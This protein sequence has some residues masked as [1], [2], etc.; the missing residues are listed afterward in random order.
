MLPPPPG[1]LDWGLVDTF[2]FSANVSEY[3]PSPDAPMPPWL[4]YTTTVT[5]ALLTLFGLLGNSLTLYGSIKFNAVSIDNVSRV[6]LECL[7]ILDLLCVAAWMLAP[8]ITLIAGHWVLGSVGCILQNF[9]GYTC[10]YFEAFIILAFSGFRLYSLVFPL[11]AMTLT[12]RKVILFVVAIGLV[13][14]TYKLTVQIYFEYIYLFLPDVLFCLAHSKDKSDLNDLFR[15]VL[16]IA[17]YL[18]PLGLTVL[19]N[20][21]ILVLVWRRSGE[22]PGRNCIITI[23]A[24]CWTFILSAVPQVILIVQGPG[25]NYTWFFYSRGLTILGMIGNPIIY[26]VANPRFRRFLMGIVRQ[27]NDD[28]TSSG[29]RPSRVTLATMDPRFSRVSLGTMDP[30]LSGMDPRLI[31]LGTTNPRVSAVSRL[32]V[33]T[34]RPR[35]SKTSRFTVEFNAMAECDKEEEK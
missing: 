31:A 27:R 1:P 7:A 26:T 6:L 23:S 20:V 18:V 10:Y 33:V 16:R 29:G 17:F 28:M 5:L 3:I 25:D 22:M 13:Y 24:V 2:M 11:R 19:S 8:C 12:P 34:P 15:N 4:Y 9:V 35:V 14:F 30:R 21:G 32:S